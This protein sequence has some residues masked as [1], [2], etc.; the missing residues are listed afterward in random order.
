MLEMRLDLTN[1]SPTQR[2]FV[3]VPPAQRP[4]AGGA[5]PGGK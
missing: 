1:V 2:L 3:T 5:R 4:A